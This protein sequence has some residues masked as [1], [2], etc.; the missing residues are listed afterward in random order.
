MVITIA[1][2]EQ[3]FFELMLS[4]P[5]VCYVPP[6]IAPI[7]NDYPSAVPATDLLFVGSDNKKNIYGINLFLSEYRSW[8]ASPSL[9]IAGR[10]CDYAECGLIHGQSVQLKGYVRD[11][12]SLYRSVRA[13]ICP[14]EGTGVNIK[15]ME[16][17]AYG[18][19]MFAY[20]SAIAGLPPGSQE[21][22]FPL[23]EESVCSL[24]ADP[25]R[26]E[27]ASR[28][29]LKYA[30]SPLIYQAWCDLRDDLR[31]LTTGQEKVPV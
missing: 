4:G 20:A 6:R 30:N 16:A 8:Q 5:K 23:T 14:V 2:N 1:P 21:C 7:E 24:L 18:K 17:L 26:L 25:E 31:R 3:T 10:V 15:A 28:A 9:A 12:P 11:L 22:V 13:V 19:P 29:A 27:K